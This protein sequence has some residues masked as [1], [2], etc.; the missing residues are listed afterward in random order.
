MH[1]LA[2]VDVTC[3]SGQTGAGEVVDEI[4]AGGAV[5]TRRGFTLVNL[6]L[7]EL[8]REACTKHQYKYYIQFHSKN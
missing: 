5:L 2:C 8:A 1:V 7:T 3:E 6:R 4:L